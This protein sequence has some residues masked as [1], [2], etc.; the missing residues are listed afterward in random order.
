VIWAGSDDGLVHVTR[1]G[2]KSW[3]NVTPPEMPEFGRVSQID[4]SAFEDGTAY[5]AV[6]RPLLNDVAPYVFR[7]HDFGRTWTKIVNGIRPND[8]VHVVREDPTRRGLLYAGTQHGVYITYDDGGTWESLSLNLPD[9]PIS[10]LIVETNAIALGTHGRSFYV[11]DDIE[12]LRQWRPEV[13]SADV[14]LFKPGEAIRSGGNASIRYV[15]RRPAQ[16]LTLDILDGRG[17]VIRTYPGLRPD[18]AGRSGAAGGGGGGGGRGGGPSGAVMTAGLHTLSWDLAYQGATT[19]PGMILWGASTA[20]PLAVPG[21]YQVRLTVDGRAQTQPITVKKH[22]LYTDVTQADLEA[23]FA[24]S[25]QIRDKLSE[26]N[27]AV[28]QIRD[29]KTQITDRVGKTTD[30]QVKA[31]GESLR[32]NLS[33][34]EEE[35]YQVRNQSGQDPLN[36]PIKI[37]NRI[38]TLL[39]TVSTG[40]GKPIANAPVIFEDLKGELKVQTDRL[41]QILGAELARFNAELRRLG[42]EELKAGRGVA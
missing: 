37:N 38:G 40:D 1:D 31:L 9:L 22:P 28:I 11:L 24:L 35:I 33:V 8:Y 2:G 5:V 14:H 20:G 10:D 36:F 15:L 25:I 34:I 19:F 18:S 13:A 16:S 6:K 21:T 27:N 4:A 26:A 29:L 12:P 41:A 17:R 39:R 23:Q 3:Q 30:A 32:K 42:I 7:T